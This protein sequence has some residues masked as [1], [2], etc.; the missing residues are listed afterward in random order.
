M[1]AEAKRRQNNSKPPRRGT[2]QPRRRSTRARVS[3]EEELRQSQQLIHETP[4]MITRCSRDLRYLFVSRAYARM[5]GRDARDIQGRSIVDVMG[6][7]GFAAIKPHVERVLSGVPVEYESE[8]PFAGVGTRT[9]QVIYKPELQDGQAIGWIASMIDVTERRTGRDA[10]ALLASIVESSFDAI[11]TKNL[12]GIITSWNGA[13]ER[14]FGYSADEMVG[15]PI[16]LL[17]PAERQSEEDDILERLRHGERIDHFETVRVAKDGRRLHPA[18]RGGNVAVVC[19][20]GKQAYGGI[21]R[22]IAA[23]RVVVILVR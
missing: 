23:E 7:Q 4:F 8:V 19:A 10:R 9:L 11:I 15:K 22:R 14:M 18:K 16:R 12:D 13:A 6:E 5:L 3:A 2:A 1:S 17:I 20:F 21:R